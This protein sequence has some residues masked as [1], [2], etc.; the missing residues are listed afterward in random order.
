M[1]LLL[2]I[3]TKSWKMDLP[4]LFKPSKE[5]EALGVCLHVLFDCSW[6]DM[7]TSLFTPDTALTAD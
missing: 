6:G 5:K 2:Q 7:S 4:E 3:S 1:I